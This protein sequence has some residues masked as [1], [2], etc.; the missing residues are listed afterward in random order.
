MPNASPISCLAGYNGKAA[1]ISVS[2]GLPG[3]LTVTTSTAFDTQTAANKCAIDLATKLTSRDKVRQ[4]MIKL[5]RDAN[6]LQ[7]HIFVGD[8]A[9]GPE[10]L[11]K[12]GTSRDVSQ[13]KYPN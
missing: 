9:I 2:H 13:T 10:Q 3:D 12:E 4:S 8:I 6:F 7:Y 11:F 1:K 5:N